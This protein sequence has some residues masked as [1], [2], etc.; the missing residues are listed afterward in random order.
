MEGGSNERGRYLIG[1]LH[2]ALRGFAFFFE[3]GELLPD[4]TYLCQKTEVGS[5]GYAMSK[6]SLERR[7]WEGVVLTV[8]VFKMVLIAGKVG[9]TWNS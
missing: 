2:I 5:Q 4:V 8:V 1:M 7:G 6:A 3:V 9:I